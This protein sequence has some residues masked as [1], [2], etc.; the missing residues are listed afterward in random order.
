MGS[1]VP[2]P[3]DV[4]GKSEDPNV[5]AGYDLIKEHAGGN[6]LVNPSTPAPTTGTGTEDAP[7]DPTGFDFV[8]RDH[9]DRQSGN[10]Y[11]VIYSL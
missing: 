10:H 1:V 4:F 2:D 9:W 7:T 3:K 11:D 5:K 6:G 8:K